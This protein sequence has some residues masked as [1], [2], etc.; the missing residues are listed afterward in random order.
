MSQVPVSQAPG[1]VPGPTSGDP[2]PGP[3]PGSHDV[4]VLR[5]VDSPRDLGAR[6]VVGVVLV[7]LVCLA[8]LAASIWLDV[9][10]E[11][12]G[13]GDRLVHGVG[14]PW[15]TNGILLAGLAAVVLVRDP[16]SGTAWALSGLGVFWALDGLAQSYLRAG[17]T[18][19]GSW[20]ASTSVLWFLDRAGALLPFVIAVLLLVFPT[21][22][23]LPGP[24]GWASR[25]ALAAM[26]LGFAVV[27]VAPSPHQDAEVPPDLD[28][29]PATIDAL[30]GVGTVVRPLTLA[31]F[32][33][34]VAVVV[35]RYQRS[36]GVERDRMRWLLWS[37]LTILLT[38]AATTVYDGPG[39][40]LLLTFVVMV[41]PGAAIT[42][43][44]VNP[45]LVSIAD[46]LARTLVWGGLAL[47]LLGID[48]AAVAVLD[49]VL[50]RTV[51]ESL[52]RSQLVALVLLLSAVVWSPLRSRAWALARRLTFGSRDA[53]YDVVAGLADRLEHAEDL[54]DRLA[55][56]AAAVA[57]AFGVSY[58]RLEVDRIG[59]GTLLTERGE[60]PSSVRGIP[61]RYRGEVVGTLE[62][63]ERGLRSRLSARDERLLAD[64][65]RQAVTAART[66][67]LA[68]ELQRSR[69]Q[70]V[71]A[72]EEE[73]RRI[74]RDLHDGLGPALSGVVFQLESA[75]LVVQRDPDAAMERVGSTAQQLQE[76]VADVRRLVHDLRPPAL[77]DRGLVGALDQLGERLSVPVRVQ[78]LALPPL[79][80]AVE[81]AAYRIAAEAMNNVARHA[82]ASRCE[83]CL[84]VEDGRLVVDV[85]DDGVGVDPA[86][87]AGVGLL[88]L[89]E[90]AEEL[91]GWTE[92][93]CPGLDG[94]GTR[95]R[96]RLP[97]GEEQ[98]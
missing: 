47:L 70:L 2:T 11:P 46:L 76:V 14:W 31:A 71:T 9:V 73:R 49:A 21:G 98:A 3:G 61:I 51:D 36:R 56:V 26:A 1:A 19:D 13:V 60:R 69:E 20:P 41:L 5:P 85:C 30:G 22:R 16:R 77:D 65:V 33:V 82:A 55:A 66:A 38:V 92:V 7:P 59:G 72:R 80:A 94:R 37:V 89:R 24:W 84:R 62:I 27:T 18:A 35:V 67:R 44:L 53:P 40:G 63:P 87:E 28:I 79:S 32:F 68:A 86:V 29:D 57:S 8:A 64:L 96:A 58:V 42:V 45:G 54:D 43:A 78:A 52:S 75:R 4:P 50:A 39:A 15:T 12:G 81:V 74:R 23:L 6:G 10:A 97:L 34:C 90:R 88:S 25:A 17:V 83:V 95:V 91:G 93:G 48:L